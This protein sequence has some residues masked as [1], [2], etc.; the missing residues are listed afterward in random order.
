VGALENV[1]RG[2]AAITSNDV[3]AV[4]W[5]YEDLTGP[6]SLIMHW[7]GVRWI[8]FP[9]PP[10]TGRT[11]ELHAITAVSSNDVWAVGE[12]I[13]YG[14]WYTL[15]MHWDGVQ[16]SVVPSPNVEEGSNYLLGV[17]ALSSND[18]W[19]VGWY[20][21]TDRDKTLTMHWNGVSWE[22]VP[23][24]N[25]PLNN[26]LVG[27]AA[28]SPNDVWAVG[29]YAG[30]GAPPQTLTLHWNG[31]AWTIK[32]SPSPSSVQ[33]VLYGVAAN[34]SNDVWAVGDYRVSGND[35]TFVMHWD[36]NQWSTV[37]SPNHPRS[38]GLYGVAALSP[39]DVW[40]VGS[41]NGSGSVYERTLT[42]RYTDPCYTCVIYFSDVRP[43]DYYYEAVRY[44]YCAGVI[45]GYSDGTFR[46]Y[47]LTTRGQLCK[48]VTLAEGWTLYTPPTPTF[49][50][51]PPT[52]PFFPYIE[53]AY[54]QGVISGYSDGTFRPQNNVTRGQLCKIVVLAEQWPLYTPPNP[55]FTD[56]PPQHTFYAHIETTYNRAIISGYA[57][58]TFRPGNN[59]TRGQISK[60]VHNAITA[61]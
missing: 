5:Y 24:P 18:V 29:R 38:D 25:A 13:Y 22:V 15:I 47:N 30:P 46:P 6:R 44:L 52:D 43:R 56:V 55:S 28:I 27:V 23:S 39:G 61:P 42:I 45:S 58:G 49:S 17:S 50:D 36:G 41:G 59:A 10:V 21:G 19:A 34:T 40:A 20:Y 8:H 35:R 31:V 53:T 26:S 57:D 9:S 33:T 54:Q 7:D 32:P 51:V 16:W 1:L 12:Y 11:N 60:I 37:P 48:I 14:R 4:G 3:W 2:V